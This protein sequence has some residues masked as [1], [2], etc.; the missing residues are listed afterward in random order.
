MSSDKKNRKQL[1][2]I[3]LFLTSLVVTLIIG[4]EIIRFKY[5]HIE[6]ITGLVTWQQAESGRGKSHYT[7]YWDEYHPQFGWTN[8]R[9][10]QSNQ[11]VPFKVS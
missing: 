6:E 4:E 2:A 9:N 1:P 5:D 7:Y 11:K 10:Y 3:L 8:Q